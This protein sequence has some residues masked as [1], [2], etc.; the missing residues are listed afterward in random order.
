MKTP[1]KIAV[2]TVVIILLAF[3]YPAEK[4]FDIAKN[5]DIFA[6]L[7]KEVN[8]HYVDEVAPEKLVRNGIDA[9]L[10]SLDPYTNYIAEEE[11]ESFRTMT[12]GQYAG[13]GAMIGRVG[14]KIVFTHPY[15]GF[16][17]SKVGIKVGDEIIEIDGID[18]R[19]K[20]PQQISTMLKGNANTEINV[21]VKRF[22]NNTPV[23]YNIKREKISVKNV[24]FFGM[25]SED[26]GLI[27]LDDFTPG[28]GREVAEALT[29]LKSKGAKSVILDLRENPGGI[30]QEA[31][32]VANVFIPKGKA[33]VSTKGKLADWDKTYY[34]LNNT[35]DTQI[36][37]A[38][39]VGPTSA[40]ASEI[41]AGALQ[42]Y[43]RA[44]LIGNRTFGKGLVQTT[45]PLSYNGQL[46]V[47][48]AKYYI[49]S[50]RCIQAIDYQIK[51]SNGI[52]SKQADSL[53]VEFRTKNGR[54]V[55]DGSGIE[56]DIFVEKEV[57]LPITF[58]L[59]I[60]GLIFD[61]ATEYYYNNPKN[62][63][64]YIFEFT[65]IDYRNFIQWISDKNFE[66]TSTT[67]ESIDEL[68]ESVIV[69]KNQ[70][71]LAQQIQQIKLK[72][73]Q[74]KADDL[75][76]YKDQINN[77]LKQEIAFRY[78]HT[79]GQVMQSIHSDSEIQKALEILKVISE[80]NSILINK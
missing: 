58:G 27:K 31:V 49:P 39:L 19:K 67:E 79:E 53:R 29:K 60:Q 23:T 10:G 64:S 45:R 14:N 11:L 65:E 32:N 75:I 16:P 76:N 77:L 17:A 1:Y 59:L 35:V 62:T 78:H 43:D 15:E 40:S 69:D 41:V 51:D 55:F 20:S 3:T 2:I 71:E 70:K 63:E 25:I 61:F 7:F 21:K 6:T 38:I 5:L 28:A 56:P 22:G 72:I 33:V 47:T 9:M 44:V 73:Y 13:I 36:P 37:L 24:S 66:Y 34:T 80:F 57:L 8:L 52:A 4:Y 54:T 68:L 30:L 12:T 42:D 18:V 46:K 48:T 26:V 50:G 74:A